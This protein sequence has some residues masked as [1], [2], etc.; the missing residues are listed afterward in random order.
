MGGGGGGC[1]LLSAVCQCLAYQHGSG[2]VWQQ[3][4]QSD[5]HCCTRGTGVR[6]GDRY[7]GALYGGKGRGQI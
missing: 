2:T 1:G 3:P 5:R 4:A 6:D 7:K